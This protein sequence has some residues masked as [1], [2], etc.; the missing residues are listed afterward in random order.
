MP[1]IYPRRN[2]P[3]DADVWGR[4]VEVR[5]DSTEMS[6]EMLQQSVQG[7]NRNTASSLQVLAGQIKAVQDAQAAIIVTQAQIQAAQADILATTNFLSTQTASDSRT[8]SDMFTGSHSGTTWWTYNPT[9]DCSVT[10][11][12]G[13]AGRLLIQATSNLIVGDLTA[14]LGLEVVGQAGPSFP[15]PYSTYLSS[16]SGAASGVTRVHVF[17]GSANTSYTVRTRRGTTGTGSGSTGWSSTSLV[18]TRS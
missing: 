15:G 18:V 11:Q 17:S 9:Y 7:Q 6:V 10:L 8:N 16:N 13:S 1:D 5:Q 2:L 12:T 4:T 3:G 14:L